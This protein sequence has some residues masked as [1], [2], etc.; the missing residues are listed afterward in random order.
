MP[1]PGVAS[2]LCRITPDA[3]G[4]LPLTCV[5]EIMRVLPVRPAP[6]RIAGLCGH[7]M[8]RGLS[9]PVV[10]AALLL[11]RSDEPTRFVNL[12]SGSRQIALAVH[13]VLGVVDLHPDGGRPVPLFDGR[14]AA[15]A[16]IDP[17][18]PGLLLAVRRVV[19]DRG[20]ELAAGAAAR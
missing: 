10:D 17:G 15:L 7:A 16:A 3:L 4:A 8:I 6:G 14:V 9:T 11:G 19:D 18:L 1:D 5:R 2:L 12:I 13:Q 20:A